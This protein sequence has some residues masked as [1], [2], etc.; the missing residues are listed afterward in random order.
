MKTGNLE[1]PFKYVPIVGFGVDALE[2]RKEQ[3]S[4]VDLEY[5]VNCNFPPLSFFEAMNKWVQRLNVI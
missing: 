4:L 2:N 3:G 1:F 5:Q